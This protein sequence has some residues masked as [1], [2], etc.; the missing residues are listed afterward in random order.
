VLAQQKY[1][2]TQQNEAQR[3]VTVRAHAYED[4][5]NSQS[6]ITVRTMPDGKVVM[7]PSG[8][9][10]V[11]SQVHRS[12]TSEIE[13]LE[14]L[15]TEKLG[16]SALAATTGSAAPGAAPESAVPVAW[17]EPAYDPNTWGPGDF[18]CLP[19]KLA[20]EDQGLLKLKLSNGEDADVVL[21]LA[22]APELCRSPAQCRLP[23]GC[24]ALGLGDAQQ[25][26]RLAE[27]LVNQEVA[28]QATLVRSG[29]PLVTLDLTRH[30]LVSKAMAQVKPAAAPSNS[31]Q[32]GGWH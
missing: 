23:S 11:E 29:Q 10:V 19:V 32:G 28:P 12:L 9:L 8:G 25:V 26:A 7:T 2:V 6:F 5:P 17:N 18:T 31:A 13:A 3:Q 30:G 21:S 4:D 20:P 24:P 1:Q 15:L 22:F 16:T 14:K 27:R